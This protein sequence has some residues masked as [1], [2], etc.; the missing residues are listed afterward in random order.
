MFEVPVLPLHS[1]ITSDLKRDMIEN[2]MFIF[3]QSVD[4]SGTSHFW[5][6]AFVS[7]SHTWVSKVLTHSNLFSLG[8]VVVSGVISRQ[9]LDSA[10]TLAI[11]G[12]AKMW[13]IL[14][15]D[16][17][18]KYQDMTWYLSACDYLCIYNIRF[19]YIWGYS[20]C[21]SWF[22]TCLLWSYH[23]F[24]LYHTTINLSQSTILQSFQIHPWCE[25][26]RCMVFANQAMR[27]ET[28]NGGE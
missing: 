5:W 7:T 13:S 9:L 14:K 10:T 19:E 6:T 22:Y 18:K 23:L 3:L 27:C 28:N 24:M 15:A 17:P 12:T 4:W 2:D 1:W 16:A 8:V 20:V 11:E 21:G 25:S 26:P